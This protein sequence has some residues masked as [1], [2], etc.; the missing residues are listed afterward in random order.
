MKSTLRTLI[1]LTVIFSLGAMLGLGCGSKSGSK[2]SGDK[3]RE[4]ANDLYNREL[5]KQAIDQY[6][7]Y[8]SA[9]NISDKEQANINYIIGDIYFDRLKD[10]E[11]AL[12]YYLKVKH[13]YPE[14]SLMEEVNKKVVAC[15]ER[16]ERS[17]DAQQ[18]L[19]ET[20]SLDPGSVA[21]NRPG[22]VIARIGNR[23]ITM[24][25]LNF[26]INQLPPNMREQFT[27]RKKKLDFLNQYLTTEILF[28]SAKR[29]G[30]DNDKD[31]L[32]QAFQAKKQ[33]MV[34]KLLEQRVAQNIQTTE[35][36]LQLYYEA[37][38]DKYTEK[39]KD[40]NV[41]REKSMAEVR[42]QVAQDYYQ[43]RYL[44]EI[45]RLIAKMMEAES[46]QIF[47]DKIQ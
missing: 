15:L 27:D 11:N 8:L 13:F 7:L 37:N 5:F 16:L 31:V 6:E 14:T 2:V 4:F 25:D 35:T 33:F 23:N 10:Y 21:P 44:D 18:A 26:G 36:D 30:L 1:L 38:K 45:Q 47:E 24:G 32:E 42:D 20:T 40:G 34:Y 17:V 41:L 19:R 29:E 12:T 22:E 39:D 43:K 9:Y 46:V 3:I 28:N